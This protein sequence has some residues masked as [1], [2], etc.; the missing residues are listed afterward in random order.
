MK[1]L[2]L[3][4]GALFLLLS[5]APP[6]FAD[7][8]TGVSLFPSSNTSVATVPSGN[9]DWMLGVHIGYVFP[10]S[11]YLS[12]DSITLPNY[13]TE[14][15]SAG[16]YH[17]PSFL[18]LFDFGVR[19]GKHSLYGFAQAGLN[20][21][22]VYDTGFEPL[23]NTGAN[24]RAGVGLR[25]GIWGIDLSATEVYPTFAAVGRNLAGIVSN[26]TSS[27]AFQTFADNLIWSA[28]INLYFP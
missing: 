14:R 21:L 2:V 12:W 18:N 8:E 6:V 24:L 17:V 19:A 28:G 27:G 10:H 20:N 7:W 22:W 5:F 9:F 1:R 16:A 26:G 23:V 4:L 3:P 15:L 13:L 11:G 25:F